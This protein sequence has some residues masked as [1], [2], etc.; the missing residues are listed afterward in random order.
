MSGRVSRENHYSFEEDGNVEDVSRLCRHLG[1]IVF[2]QLGESSLGSAKFARVRYP[3]QF[4]PVC[5]DGEHHSWKTPL[6]LVRAAPQKT[7]LCCGWTEVLELHRLLGCWWSMVR[8]DFFSWMPSLYCSFN[9][10][11]KRKRRNSSWIHPNW[12]RILSSHQ[13][14]QTLSGKVWI[15]E[16]HFYFN[17]RLEISVDSKTWKYIIKCFKVSSG[18]KEETWSAWIDEIVLNSAMRKRCSM[19]ESQHPVWV[20]G[21]ESKNKSLTPH[22]RLRIPQ[23]VIVVVHP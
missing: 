9:N 16:A 14:T 8:S 6:L 12:R 3:D 13:K 1:G 5:R 2:P 10:L 7:Q 11:G 22:S 23:F 21:C 17:F 18:A 4:R 19:L 15:Q 20:I